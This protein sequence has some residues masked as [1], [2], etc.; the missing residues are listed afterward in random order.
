[1]HST[2][3]VS[4]AIAALLRTLAVLLVLFGIYVV[5]APLVITGF[6][7]SLTVVRVPLIYFTGAVILWILSKPIA[8][9]IVRGLD[10]QS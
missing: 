6:G 3:I 9:I 1:M 7:V 8:G 10:G 2:R 4:L 5:V